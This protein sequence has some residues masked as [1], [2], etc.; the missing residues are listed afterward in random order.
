MKSLGQRKAKERGQ[1]PT[2]HKWPKKGT[3]VTQSNRRTAEANA[4]EDD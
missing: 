4:I 2:G 1:E 3:E